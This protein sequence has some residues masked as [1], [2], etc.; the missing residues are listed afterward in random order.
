MEKLQRWVF[1]AAS[2]SSCGSSASTRFDASTHK[3]ILAAELPCQARLQALAES[4]GHIKR[5]AIADQA[6]NIALWWPRY[7]GLTFFQLPSPV[8]HAPSSPGASASRIFN[9]A[10]S[11]RVFTKAWLIW[12]TSAV[13]AILRF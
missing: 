9:L 8:L 2:S 11:N 6:D 5:T 1:V 13:S 10:R 3:Q 7:Q 12:R 4:C